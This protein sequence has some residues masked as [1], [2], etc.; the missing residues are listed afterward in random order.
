MQVIFVHSSENCLVETQLIT[1]LWLHT[2]LLYEANFSI[3]DCPCVS[4][5]GFSSEHLN[6]SL[7]F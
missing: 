7:V 3:P 1:A 5:F 6:D 2:S 4:L